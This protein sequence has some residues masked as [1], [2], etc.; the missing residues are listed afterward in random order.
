MSP[1]ARQWLIGCAV[2]AGLAVVLVI[3]SCVGFMVWLNQPGETL[4]PDRLLAADTTGIVEWTARMDDPGTSRFVWTMLETIQ[5]QQ[6]EHSPLPHGLALWLDKYQDRKNRRQ[7][8]LLFPLVV[9]WTMRSGGLEEEPLDLWTVNL[10]NLGHRMV[11]GEWFFGWILS[12]DKDIVTTPYKDETLYAVQFGDDPKNKDSVTIFV[13][14]ASLFLTSDTATARS[15]VDRLQLE[16]PAEVATPP[17]TSLLG[18]ADTKRALRGAVS[19]EHG[20]IARTI[21]PLVGKGGDRAAILDR[22]GAARSLV[23]SGGF[24]SETVFSG[25]IELDYIDAASAAAH[26]SEI[27]ADLTYMLANIHLAGEVT[28]QV[29]GP[30]VR[31]AYQIDDPAAQVAPL[32]KLDWM[33]GRRRRSGDGEKDE[34]SDGSPDAT[35]DG[36]P[37]ATRD[38]SPDAT[39]D[40]SGDATAD[41]TPH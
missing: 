23:L 13:R 41:G 32:L 17:L 20:E 18:R 27:S 11:L 24:D 10:P 3:G 29:D 36:T 4:V 1:R 12:R 34:D 6:R 25:T 39:R 40:G 35:R 33:R 2:A 5:A 31:L 38:G 26:A 19:N 16:I 14:G 28:P 21:G 9:A 7:V 22:W 15:A 8:Q 37:D 30:M